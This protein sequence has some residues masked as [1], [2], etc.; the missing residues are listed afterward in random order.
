VK[1]DFLV[2]EF[3]S[4]LLGMRAFLDAISQASS[5][6]AATEAAEKL[7]K[8]AE[9]EGWAAEEYFAED[10]V[11]QENFEHWLPRLSTY[12]VIILL[13]SLVETQLHTCARKLRRDRAL[14]LD[15]KDL[16]GVGV[17]PAKTYLVKVANL[18]VAD[19]LGWQELSNLQDIRNI[20]IHRRGR[21]GDSI[22]QRD[23]VQRLLK[24]YPEDLILSPA[25]LHG[26]TNTNEQDIIITPRLCSHFLNEIDAFFHRLFAAA[27]FQ[28]SPIQL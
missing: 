7:K 23:L 26:F 24:E 9:S 18:D 13:Q 3:N 14:N 10:D 2:W 25:R 27:G 4:W 20:I 17:L 5:E 28:E 21:V 19:D 15:V 22:E 1:I 16:Y 12:A 6:A 11:L 8:R